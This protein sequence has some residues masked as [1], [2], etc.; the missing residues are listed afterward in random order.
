M[1]TEDIIDA[2]L[3]DEPTP[4][5]GLVVPRSGPGHALSPTAQR[6]IAAAQSPN[7]MR[8]RARQLFARAVKPG[9]A[10]T[11]V[12]SGPAGAPWDTMAWVLWCEQHGHRSGVDG[13][14]TAEVLADWAAALTEWVGEDGRQIGAPT[15]A[16]ALAAVRWL[17]DQHGHDGQPP[18]KL[19]SAVLAGYR[20]L[21]AA[22]DVDQASPLTVP[23]LRRFVSRVD[24]L[25][26]RTPLLN[27]RDKVMLLLGVPGMLRRSELAALRQRHVRVTDRGLRLY[28]ASSKTDK[29]AQGVSVALPIGQHPET[30]PRTQYLAWRDMLAEHGLVEEDGPVLCSVKVY[31]QGSTE[32]LAGNPLDGR[33]IDRAVKT[34]A[35]LAGFGAG[36]WSGHSMRAGG[37]TSAYL[38]GADIRSI[39]QQGRWIKV[40]TVMRY[41]RNV[42]QW[43]HNAAT[44]MDL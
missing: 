2:E 27:Q 12:D 21:G 23:L 5:T 34:I 18:G 26:P 14:A 24:E 31:G 40:E 41:I 32:R 19:A 36:S 25:R 3:V 10:R 16:Q 6:L 38:G 11:I 9:P 30:C 17:H 7:S 28:V 13:P 39:M 42:E 33:D 37:A 43:T 8:A 20:L 44:K 35:E 4:G 22:E 1:S 29:T 15:I